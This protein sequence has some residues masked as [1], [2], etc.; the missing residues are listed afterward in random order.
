[1]RKNVSSWLML[2]VVSMNSIMLDF[3]E[4]PSDRVNYFWCASALIIYKEV[5]GSTGY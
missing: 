5:S 4:L 3:S 2:T 1:M